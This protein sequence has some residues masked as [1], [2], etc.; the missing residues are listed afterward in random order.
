MKCFVRLIVL[1]FLALGLGLAQTQT[2]QAPDCV[3][4]FTFGSTGTGVAL[5]NIPQ[6]ATGGST[7]GCVYWSV[8]ADGF[9]TGAGTIVFQSNPT[10]N[11]AGTAAPV[12]GWVTFSTLSGF[13]A[14][15]SNPSSTFPW[16]YQT[17]GYAPW[18]RVACTAYTSGTIR[19]TVNGWRKLSASSSG[20]GGSSF[21]Q[22]VQQAGTA[23]PQRAI[24]NFAANT[25]CV[26]NAGANSTD[27]TPS[28]GG[29]GSF[30][31]TVKQAGSALPQQPALNFTGAGVTC[32]N[33][34]GASSTDCAISG[35][36]GGGV[37]IHHQFFTAGSHNGSCMISA[38][39]V[40]AIINGS[41]ATNLCSGGNNFLVP[42]I[43]GP[44]NDS[45]SGLIYAFLPST[46]NGSAVTLTLDAMT[47]TNNTGTVIFQPSFA[48]IPNGT[49][50]VAPL[51][52]VTGT[53]VTVSAPG[54]TGTGF[55]RVA[56][57]LTVTATGCTPGSGI[58]LQWIRQ[59][60]TYPNSIYLFGVDLAITY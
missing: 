56:I 25:T 26:D 57:A 20:G 12:T 33:N 3:I 60:D 41:T 54:G 52:F 48:C 35:G 5:N 18:V 34:G 58:E 8:T 37:T 2:R 6:V 39:D 7:G 43:V 23:K 49:D 47:S 15:G 51:T 59:T 24:L 27:C 55:Y 22:T 11:T 32:I 10:S 28:G 14:L 17:A 44:I 46:W 31:Q 16:T 30:Y 53:N 36:G 40:N 38:A 1:I 13:T 4:N 29:G 42:G 50:V 9:N 45:N 21:Y 19:G